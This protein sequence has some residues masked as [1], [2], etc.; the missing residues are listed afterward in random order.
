L[1]AGSEVV[2]LFHR[3]AG[4]D[5]SGA[6]GKASPGGRLLP[7]PAP[8]GGFLV[9]AG[10]REEVQG[11]PVPNDGP[12]QFE[13]SGAL[14]THGFAGLLR[15]PDAVD[16]G[17]DRRRYGPPERLDPPAPE[18]YEYG[19]SHDSLVVAVPHPG[20][21]HVLRRDEKRILSVGPQEDVR[22]CAVSPDGR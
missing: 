13:A 5:A 9:D 12:L 2:T 19:I 15:W 20:G 3:G 22:H 4:G 16:A 6:E 7:V 14:L 17:T 18:Y 8:D 1:R 11:L 21:A 10:L